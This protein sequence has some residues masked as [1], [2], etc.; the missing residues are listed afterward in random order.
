MRLKGRTPLL[1]TGTNRLRAVAVSGTLSQAH[2][3]KTKKCQVAGR[4]VVSNELT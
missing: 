4:N 1:V 2:I 3:L